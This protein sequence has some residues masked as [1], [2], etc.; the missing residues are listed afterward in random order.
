VSTEYEQVSDFV[1]YNSYTTSD[2]WSRK[3][4]YVD[5]YAA[6][7]KEINGKGVMK[8]FIFYGAYTNAIVTV[9]IN[10]NKQQTYMSR[11]FFG[12]TA[13]SDVER[14]AQDKVSSILYGRTEE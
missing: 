4:V 6:D 9:M 3:Y 1:K 12:E 14:W 13:H 2:D 7:A 5:L 10:E 8:D 11:I